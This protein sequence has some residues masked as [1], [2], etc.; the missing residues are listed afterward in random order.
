[1]PMIKRIRGFTLIELM[2]ALALNLFLLAGLID[3]F[4]VNLEH[5]RKVLNSSQLEEQLQSAIY[6]M[7]NEIRRAGYSG[8]AANDVF[9]GQNNNAFM[10][11]TT[12]ISV[13]G[14]NNCVLL[15]Y[16]RAGTGSLPAISS[17]VDDERYGFRLSGSTLQTRPPG[18]AFSC[19]AAVSAWENMIDSNVITITALTF[20]LNTTTLAANTSHLAIRSVDISITGQLASNSAVTKTLTAHV[21]ARNDKYIP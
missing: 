5:Y 14:S 19:A 18:A 11:A 12:D 16:D 20:T 3:I 1:M 8:T 17:G 21:R 15:T 6:F 4:V 13:N 9:S 7:T 2:I 10:T